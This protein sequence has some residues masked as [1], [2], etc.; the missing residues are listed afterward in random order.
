ML[1]L[2]DGPMS[3]DLGAFKRQC[4]SG[5][6]GK[7]DTTNSLFSKSVSKIS[8][9][10]HMENPEFLPKFHAALHFS[11]TVFPLKTE[12]PTYCS[13]PPP[14]P[15]KADTKCGASTA[16]SELISAAIYSKLPTSYHLT[17]FNLQASTFV[18]STF[19]RRTSGQFLGTLGRVKFC[20]SF[21]V[22]NIISVISP[23]FLFSSS[24]FFC[25]RVSNRTVYNLKI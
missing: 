25:L 10:W 22:Y 23:S 17:F 19:K 20:L 9:L 15:K 21:P 3:E 5:N 18:Q 12:I 24:L 13:P 2:A 7:L 14:S 11:H 16:I 4:C 6:R 1:F 8:M